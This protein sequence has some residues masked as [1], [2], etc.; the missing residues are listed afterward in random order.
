MP[1][2]LGGLS[3][4]SL[5]WDAASFGC[6]SLIL[7]LPPLLSHRV[8]DWTLLLSEDEVC[9]SQAERGPHLWWLQGGWLS[10][11]VYSEGGQA[12]LKASGAREVGSCLKN[13]TCGPHLQRSPERSLNFVGTRGTLKRLSQDTGLFLER[14]L[15]TCKASKPFRHLSL[16]E[17][18]TKTLAA[19]WGS[20]AECQHQWRAGSLP[21]FM[22]GRIWW[23]PT[24]CI[25]L[26]IF[27]LLRAPMWIHGGCAVTLLGAPY[28]LWPSRILT[29]FNSSASFRELFPTS[30]ESRPSPSITGHS[31]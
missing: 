18:N 8:W 11:K 14:S 15:R 21:Q 27:F 5:G 19:S 10:W 23:E 31:L 6:L 22:R 1:V 7:S 26:L 3:P 28:G 30:A 13:H 20:L 25:S 12:G 24:I 9:F 2:S 4:V 29:C 16:R 17:L